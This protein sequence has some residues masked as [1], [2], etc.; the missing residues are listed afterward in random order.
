ML[1]VEDGHLNGIQKSS[2]DKQYVGPISYTLAE[3]SS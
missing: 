2:V 1:S 3:G